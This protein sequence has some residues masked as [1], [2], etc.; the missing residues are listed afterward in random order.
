MIEKL[1]KYLQGKKTVLAGLVV[2]ALSFIPGALE[3]LRDASAE[4]GIPL[5]G[6]LAALFLGLRFVT[7]GKVN[8]ADWGKPVADAAE[9]RIENLPAILAVGL[10]IGSLGMASCTS[11][12]LKD[13]W[14]RARAEVSVET[15]PTDEIP[16]GG[17][18]AGFEIFGLQ[19]GG[20]VAYDATALL[21]EVLQLED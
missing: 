17:Y 15:G 19:I 18:R 13:N 7:K 14:N 1:F 10:A 4:A 11:A 9:K 8:L 2:M 12:E 5:E 3:Y 21:D 16:D 20:Y 6:A